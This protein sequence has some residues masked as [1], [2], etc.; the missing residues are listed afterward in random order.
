M[1]KLVV[2]LVAAVLLVSMS[3]VPASAADNGDDLIDEST[4][5]AAQVLEQAESAADPAPGDRAAD[6]AAE[7]RADQDEALAGAAFADD[8]IEAALAGGDFTPGDLI[9]DVNFYDKA[10][11]SESQIQGFLQQMVGSCATSLC[12]A[13]YKATTPNRTWSYGTCSPYAGAAN[14]SAAR[15]IFKVQEACGLSAK[16]IL[17]T[18]QKEQSLLTNPQPTQEVLRKAMGYGCPD[19]AACDSTYYGFFNQVYAAARQLTWYGNPGGSFTWLKVGQPNHVLFHPDDDR[20]GGASVTIANS[21]TAA[22]YYYTPYQ[23]NAAALVD[24]YGTGDSCSSYGNR[25]FWRMYSDWFGDPRSGVVLTT[26]RLEGVDRYATAVAISEASYPGGAPVV[27]IA[28]G[29]EFAD[30]LAAAPAAAHKGGP[31][32][33]T[34]ADVLPEATAAEIR[35]LA[36]QQIVVVGGDGAV[37]ASVMRTLLQIAPA[38]RIGGTDRYDT[39]RNII[40]DAFGPTAIAYLATGRDFPDGLSAGAAAGAI[41]APVVLVDGLGS[42]VDEKT[43]AL[44]R[45]KGIAEV[46]I[47]GGD[48]VVSPGIASSLAAASMT[49]KRYAGAD[50]YTTSVAINTVFAT[51][52]NAYIATGAS[53]PDALTGAAAAG[54]AGDPL[55]LAAQSCVPGAVRSAALGQGVTSL[56]LLGGRGVLAEAVGRLQ[57]C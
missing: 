31:M 2:G 48:G 25:N 6:G 30:A 36:P 26:E 10:A 18:L 4:Q 35:R 15:I 38:K 54:A 51:T 45:S 13:N 23:P 53:F 37:G 11:M 39:S 20:C 12:L 55:Y 3:A 28:S 44:L 32:L 7:R 46:R 14:E 1:K 17:V 50:R 40:A 56:T 33:L 29:T 49:V 16:V 41:G 47:A 27:Y 34:A 8:G 22:L 57:S 21:A 43:L 24:L 9:A 42:S 5:H 52:A 19:T